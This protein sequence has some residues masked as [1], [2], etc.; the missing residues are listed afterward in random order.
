M[1][2]IKI[3]CIASLLS[4]SFAYATSSCDGFE[5]KIKNN[6]ADDLLVTTIKLNGAEIQPGAIQQIDRKTAQV[7]TINSSADNVPM[8]GEF[9]FHTLSIPSKT[10]T[11]QYNLENASL[12]C[13]HTDKSPLSDYSIEKTRFPGSVHYIISNK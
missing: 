6:L 3:A 10:V 8:V 12:F 4:S 7:F 5:L 2:K 1:N 13:E 11:I 9:V